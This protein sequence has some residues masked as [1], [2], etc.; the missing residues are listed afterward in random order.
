MLY[1]ALT[2]YIQE[3]TLKSILKYVLENEVD[4]YC[5]RSSNYL[6]HIIHNIA[7]TGQ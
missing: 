2:S 1:Q 4:I 5:L 6:L 7:L 3:P